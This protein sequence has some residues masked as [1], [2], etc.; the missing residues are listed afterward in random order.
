MVFF[1]L[2]L[3]IGSGGSSESLCLFSYGFVNGKKFVLNYFGLNGSWVVL[4]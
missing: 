1:S 2:F 3:E 4:G